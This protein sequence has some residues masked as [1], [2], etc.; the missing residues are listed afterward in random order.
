MLYF[1]VFVSN[2][3][4]LYLQFWVTANREE[5]ISDDEIIKYI[6]IN[7]I[8]CLDSRSMWE[9]NRKREVG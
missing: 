9:G 8:W 5:K 2:L 4:E 6:Y 3:V 7:I 1:D